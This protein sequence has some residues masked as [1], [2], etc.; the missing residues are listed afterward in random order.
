MSPVEGSPAKPEDYPHFMS[1]YVF[2][3]YLRGAGEYYQ[4]EME[5]Q[6]I[7]AMMGECE[8]CHAISKLYTDVELTKHLILIS[9]PMSK[10]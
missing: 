9:A 3:P 2:D 10:P 4:A 7:H 1:V 8:R 6:F 5:R